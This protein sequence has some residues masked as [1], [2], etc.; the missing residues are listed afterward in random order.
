MRRDTRSCFSEDV[1]PLI[2]VGDHHVAVEETSSSGYCFTKGRDY[3]RTD[4]D[5]GNWMRYRIFGTYRN[6][7]PWYRHVTNQL[8]SRWPT[9]TLAD[10]A[11][12]LRIV[13]LITLLQSDARLA[14]SPVDKVSGKSKM[15]LQ[16]TLPARI[17]GA[18]FASSPILFNCLLTRSKC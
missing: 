12:E 7:R 6:D 3:G 13:M 11:G 2:G 18:I 15:C 1:D 8:Q 14:K 5:V 10:V 9:N 4:C 16:V 17:E